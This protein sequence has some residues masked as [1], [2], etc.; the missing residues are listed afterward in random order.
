MTRCSSSSF[1]FI[2]WFETLSNRSL[3]E[4]GDATTGFFPLKTFRSICKMKV[5]S[6][7]HDEEEKN[8]RRR[9]DRKDGIGKDLWMKSGQNYSKL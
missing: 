1:L 5:W 9:I 7:D 2:L 4:I 8:S 3:W 6:F